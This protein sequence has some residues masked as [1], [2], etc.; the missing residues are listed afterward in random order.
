MGIRIASSC[1]MSLCSDLDT[2]SDEAVKELCA[3][4][5]TF[6]N[7]LGTTRKLAG[8]AASQSVLLLCST[9]VLMYNYVGSVSPH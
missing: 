5:H 4:S 2:I 8:S 9:L 7:C 1:H 6:F 3:G